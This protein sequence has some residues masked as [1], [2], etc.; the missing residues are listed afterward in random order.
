M[1]IKKNAKTGKLFSSA[2]NFCFDIFDNRISSAGEG[3][4]DSVNEFLGS[5]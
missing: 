2:K 5:Y 3:P 4:C 1:D